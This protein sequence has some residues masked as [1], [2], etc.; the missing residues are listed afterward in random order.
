[1][2]K[3][4]RRIDAYIAKVPAFAGPILEHLRAV[5]HEGCP[6]VEET[7]KWSHPAFEYRGFFCMMAAFKEHCKFGFWRPDVRALFGDESRDPEALHQF[8]HIR[9]LADLPA[10][11]ELLKQVRQAKRIHDSGPPPPKKPRATP[12]A[13]LAIPPDLSAALA[14]NRRA[15]RAWDGLR[16]SH[17]REYVDWLVSAKRA[18]TR[19]KRLLTTLEWLEEGK[20]RYW[21]YETGASRPK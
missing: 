6:E 14:R 7:M 1:M 3:R 15:Q 11:R 21:Q 10:R 4:D 13:E 5:V 20:S 2:G 18:E 16:P 12:K 17:R 8:E 19:E 9:A